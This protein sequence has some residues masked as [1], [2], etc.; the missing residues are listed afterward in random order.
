M[1][2]R[3]IPFLKMAGA[4]N[5]FVVIDNR[6]GVIK[7][8]NLAA[9]RLC[10]RKLIGADGLLLLENT[11]RRGLKM[12]YFNRDGSEAEMCGN[13][14]RCFARF[15]SIVARGTKEVCFQAIDGPH[16]AKVQRASVSLKM[17]DSRMI[18]EDMRV[19]V[20]RKKMA[21]SLINTGVPHFVVL[22]DNVR[23]IDVAGL[24][25]TLRN[26]TSFRPHG[27]NVDFVQ[28]LGGRKIRVRTYERGVEAETRGCGTGAVAAALVASRAWGIPSPVKVL[29]ESGV[30]LE[31]AFNES[32]KTFNE[33]WLRGDAQVLFEG[34]V[35][36]QYIG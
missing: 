5:D 22:V 13:G 32:G 27:T 14:G 20:T 15:I 16:E 23:T 10:D 35:L 3:K 18:R 11:G 26:H 36:P 21:G 30:W 29:T 6:K 34:E 17:S 12:R 25:R 24:G 4:G 2:S 7:R 19:E 8:R 9:R 1:T 28:R 33:I 31:A